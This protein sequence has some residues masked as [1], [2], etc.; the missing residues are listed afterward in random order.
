MSSAEI[1]KMAAGITVTWTMR[2]FTSEHYKVSKSEVF[3]KVIPA[4]DFSIS[5]E[6]ICQKL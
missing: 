6:D 4:A 3:Q 1:Q 2:Q 5:A